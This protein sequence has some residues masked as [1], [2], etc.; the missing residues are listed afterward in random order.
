MDVSQ[1][2][3]VLRFSWDL[4]WRLAGS[5]SALATVAG[6]WVG[7]SALRC[8][9]ALLSWAGAPTA[10]AAAL[11]EA[12]TWFTNHAT[13]GIVGI[14][15]QTVGLAVS[16]RSTRFSDGTRAPATAL[17][18]A[19]LAVEC[20]WF[21]GATIAACGCI[22]LWAV[23]LGWRLV[24]VRRNGFV[25]YSDSSVLVEE[26]LRKAW[27]RPVVAGFYFPLAPIAWATRA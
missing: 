26:W 12:H 23:A 18:G 27:C 4:P 8:L 6:I 25:T 16:G 11:Q 13:L 9:A 7:G 2:L 5:I 24:T 10:V 20:G 1:L 15:L 14:L 19:A 3:S 21:L 22:A 17:L